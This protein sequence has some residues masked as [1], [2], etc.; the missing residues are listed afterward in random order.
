LFRP[1]IKKKY[2]KINKGINVIDVNYI[3][4]EK[5]TINTNSDFPTA[6]LGR[7]IGPSPN[8]KKALFFPI[9]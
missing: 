5:Y 9:L 3:S 2:V 6:F 8:E 1:H 7:N 4:F